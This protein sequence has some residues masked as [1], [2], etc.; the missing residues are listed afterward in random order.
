MGT[1]NYDVIKG[2]Y[3]V[4]KA[5]FLTAFDNGEQSKISDFVSIIYKYRN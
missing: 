1:V 3:K 5:E 2:L 4:L